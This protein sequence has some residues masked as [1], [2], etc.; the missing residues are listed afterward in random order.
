MGAMARRKLST[1]GRVVAAGLCVV[2]TGALAGLMAATD[3]TGN[4][5]AGTT[6]GRT[7]GTGVQPQNVGGYDADGD[8]RVGDPGDSSGVHGQVPGGFSDD[9][10]FGDDRFGDDSSSG[11]SSSGGTSTQ[12]Y[13][14]QPQTRTGGS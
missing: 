4:A 1:Q 12:P 8:G 5:S 13:F 14:P 3:D 6:G 9:D 7:S 10:R 2:V 11:A